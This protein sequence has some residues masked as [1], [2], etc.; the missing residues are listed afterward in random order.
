MKAERLTRLRG[1][2]KVMLLAMATNEVLTIAFTALA[3]RI[4]PELS[5]RAIQLFSFIS[6][7]LAGIWFQADAKRA[8]LRAKSEGYVVV[9]QL[10]EPHIAIR[11]N[12]PKR[13]LVQLYLE[14]NPSLVRR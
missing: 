5:P 13:W 14:L 6:A 10:P 8:F 1:A 12:C 2:A 9:R 4:D 3:G 11:D 7:M